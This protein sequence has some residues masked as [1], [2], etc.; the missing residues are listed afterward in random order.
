MHTF[1]WQ[2]IDEPR[3]EIA[4]VESLDDAHGT[5]IGLAYE[6][7]W[8]LTG[9]TLTVDIGDGPIHHHLDGADYFDLQHSAFFNSL[10]V[11]TDGLLPPGSA[12]RDYTMRFVAVPTL[13]ATLTPQRYVPRTASTVTF[14]S[15]T[16][17]ADMDFDLDGY[18][19]LYHEYLRRLHP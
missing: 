10:P 14:I 16:Y 5:Q 3:M 4:Y 7:R 9:S 8:Q 12:P 17:E 6:L 13:T 2:G 19:T 1:I 15:G 11:L 18:V